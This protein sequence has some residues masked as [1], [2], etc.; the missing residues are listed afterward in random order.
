MLSRIRPICA[1]FVIILCSISFA[2]AQHAAGSVNSLKKHFLTEMSAWYKQYPQENVFLQTDRNIYQRGDTC[3]YKCFVM[4]YGRPSTLSRIMYVRLCDRSGRMIDEQKLSL[5]DGIA[6]GAIAIPDSLSGGWY[7]LQAFTAWML[8]FGE[9]RVFRHNIL[10]QDSF[11]EAVKITKNSQKRN[12]HIR[13]YPEGGTIAADELNNVAFKA[14]DNNGEPVT[15]SGVVFGRDKRAVAKFETEHDGMGSFKIA[16]DNGVQYQAEVHFPDSR[17]KVVNLP[18][19]KERGIHLW[20]ASVD[21]A[22]FSVKVDAKSNMNV[23]LTAE[24]ATG[25]FT[26][27]KLELRRGINEFDFRN[28]NFSTGILRLKIFDQ[29]GF[30]LSGRNIFI[31]KCDNPL[32]SVVADSLSFRPDGE[33]VLTAQIKNYNPINDKTNLSVSVTD[34]EVPALFSYN[35]CSWMLLGAELSGQVYHPS[36][37]FQKNSD[38]LRK[39]LDLVMLTS[40]DPLSRPEWDATPATKPV[41]LKYG[42]EKQQVIAGRILGYRASDDCSVKLQIVNSDS[43]RNFLIVEPDSAGRF[44]VQGYTRP[45]EARI[46]YDIVDRHNRRKNGK[47]DFFRPAFDS[48]QFDTMLPALSGTLPATTVNSKSGTNASRQTFSGSNMLKTVRIKS[49]V[50]STNELLIKKYVRHLEVS[51]AEDLD[52][53]DSSLPAHNLFEYL[54]GRVPGL[55]INIAS[56]GKV[57]FEYRGARSL[58]KPNPQ[59]GGITGKANNLALEQNP[60]ESGSEIVPYFYIDEAL[61]TIDDVEALPLTDIALVRFVSPPVYFAPLNGGSAGALLIYTKRS[62]GNS[63]IRN[64][65][66]ATNVFVYKSFSPKILFPQVPDERSIAGEHTFYWNAD[67][68]PD[69]NGLVKIRFRNGPFKAHQ[70]YLSLQLLDAAGHLGFARCTFVSNK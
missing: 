17:V 42:V 1:I 30:V 47:V 56:D 37:Y 9:R 15:V 55:T 28:D 70:Y 44:Y 8:N 26:V 40:E 4:A 22:G 65:R 5:K 19:P 33:N 46:F 58:P 38:S 45:G 67:L 39:H 53:Q 23:M 3:W 66:R 54:Q 60:S 29:N 31:D 69:K 36:Y 62:G 51:H 16:A 25:T 43:T 63:A 2:Q 20:M 32:L 14:V 59:T 13:F 24:Q 64:D 61:S 57:Y 7:Q 6:F 68:D 35:I 21:S 18:E 34:A 12:Y 10:L 41:V 27:V 49:Q 52:I 48:V 11:Y 50:M